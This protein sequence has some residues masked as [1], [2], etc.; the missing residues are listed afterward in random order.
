MS[1]CVWAPMCV[2]GSGGKKGPDWLF[3]QWP[4]ELIDPHRAEAAIMSALDN[5]LRHVC[6]NMSSNNVRYICLYALQYWSQLRISWWK[7]CQCHCYYFVANIMLLMKR[8]DRPW[9]QKQNTKH[10]Q[11]LTHLLYSR[12]L[13]ATTTRFTENP[14]LPVNYSNE[15]CSHKW[16]P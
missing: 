2:G 10:S 1:A 9:P 5:V 12:V 3:P 15:T 6:Q 8:M 11:V 13:C 14:L 16:E 7:Q 4:V